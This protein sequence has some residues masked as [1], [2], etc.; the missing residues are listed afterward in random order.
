M[1]R[2]LVY[3]ALLGNT[4]FRVHARS[5]HIRACR[6]RRRGKQC[7]TGGFMLK[8][9]VRFGL[10]G[11]PYSAA[12]ASTDFSSVVPV[13]PVEVVVVAATGAFS[14]GRSMISMSA[15]GALSVLRW[16]SFTMRQ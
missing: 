12:G 3:P 10:N 1:P 5:W 6:A 13:D 15:I 16:P 9:P 2:I 4:I 7:K 8:P 14:C 11:L